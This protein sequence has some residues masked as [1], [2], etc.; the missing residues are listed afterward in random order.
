MPEDNPAP[1]G[2]IWGTGD[3]SIDF[4]L[5]ADTVAGRE[6]TVLAE[7]HAEVF[8]TGGQARPRGKLSLHELRGD[9]G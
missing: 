6:L 7:K 1:E 9:A 4:D 3:K 5:V 2:G 8:A